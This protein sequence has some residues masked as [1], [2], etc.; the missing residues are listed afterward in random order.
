MKRTGY[1]G[2]SL[3]LIFAM[4]LSALTGFAQATKQAKTPAEYNAYLA[5]YNEKDP[6]KKAG[7]GEKFVADFKESDFLMDAYVGTIAAYS[8]A[9]N[10]Q[11]VIQVADVA[12]GM[13]NADNKVK[14]SAYFNSMVAAQNLNDVDKVV[15]YGEK[16]LTI[17]P[18]E[19]N[20]LVTLSQVIPA[21]LPTDDAGK[22]TALDKAEG[23]AD[24]ALAGV[25]GMLGKADATTKAQLVPV[26]GNLLATKG[27]IAYNRMDYQKSIEQYELAV[28]RTPKDDVAHFYL[29]LDYQALAVQASKQLQAA[30]DEENKA[31]KERAEQPVLDELAARTGGLT[32]D[33]RKFRDKSIDEFAIAAAL[34]G[35]VAAQAKT[36]LTQMWSSKNDSTAGL[37]EFIEQKKKQLQ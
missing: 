12:A 22:K 4:A 8:A 16:L 2:F 7:L 25:Q 34:N 18:N 17:D 5:F 9:K 26:E 14:S 32:D 37:E 30:V 36:A 21:K 11:K 29:A 27:L 33:V 20:A 31:K 24:K 3:L 28:G 35:P 13:P 19:L 23:Y 10:W 6:A 1:L 15:S